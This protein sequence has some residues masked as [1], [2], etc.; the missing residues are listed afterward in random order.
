MVSL[1]LIKPRVAAS[2]RNA[3]ELRAAEVALM[4]ID[5]DDLLI[6]KSGGAALTPQGRLLMGLLIQGSM[7]VKEALIYTPLSYRAFYALLTRLK[8][9]A[10]VQV[11][12]TVGDRR[13]RRLTLG[14]RFNP[15]ATQLA[16]NLETVCEKVAA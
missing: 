9:L 16:T 15:I 2:H 8:E 1:D 5:L 10:L 13:V 7:T 3:A 6:K 4:L 12:P 14:R 11:E